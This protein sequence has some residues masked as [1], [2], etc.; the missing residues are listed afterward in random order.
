M[1]VECVSVCLCRPR[2]GLQYVTHHQR[3]VN[4]ALM[5]VSDYTSGLSLSHSL[6]LSLPLAFSLSQS[7]NPL[8]LLLPWH[9][10]KGGGWGVYHRRIWRESL[11]KMDG[12]GPEYRSCLQ[13]TPPSPLQKELLPPWRREARGLWS[14]SNNNKKK[15]TKN[16]SAPAPSYLTPHPS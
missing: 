15:I 2:L 12:C 7:F 4:T 13:S 9:Y 11:V 10:R 16:P 3:G 8:G 6:P 1:S 14:Y 5:Q